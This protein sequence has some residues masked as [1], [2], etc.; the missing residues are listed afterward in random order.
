MSP[1]PTLKILLSVLT[2][3]AVAGVV[4]WARKHPNRSKE[5]PQQQ[6]MPKFVPAVGWL[7]LAVGSLMGLL[8]FATADVAL[9]AKISSVAILLGG[10]LFVLM[11]RN[12]YVV[13]RTYKVVFRSVLGRATT[14][15]HPIP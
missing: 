3:A 2:T 15:P 13:P 5:Y 8:S 14:R 4:W 12:F 9:G 11:Y 10:V 7:F 1:A 6:R